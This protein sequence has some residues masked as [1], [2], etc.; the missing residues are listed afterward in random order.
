MVSYF[1]KIL[2]NSPCFAQFFSELSSLN[3]TTIFGFCGKWVILLMSYRRR[4]IDEYYKV[5]LNQLLSP[6]I[7][8]T[9]NGIS[10]SS[11]LWP[12]LS[13]TWLVLI[14]RR[15]CAINMRHMRSTVVT[16]D[17]RQQS[18]QKHDSSDVGDG[19]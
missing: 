9:D 6:I 7:G 14:G 4:G 15:V 12:L 2:P 8:S 13:N 3:L 19:K 5:L 11:A 18:L 1:H 17:N 10:T 16:F